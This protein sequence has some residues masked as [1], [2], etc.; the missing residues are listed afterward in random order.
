MLEFGAQYAER[1]VKNSIALGTA[2]KK[3]G[4]PVKMNRKNEITQSHQV[5]LKMNSN[6]G[7]EAKRIL[8]ECGINIDAF[9]RIGTAEVTR[10]GYKEKEMQT[11]AELLHRVM[12]DK[13]DKSTIK[14]E[15]EELTSV[16]SEIEYCFTDIDD[17]LKL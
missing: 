2:L 17:A 1:V 8:E 3:L 10:R 14:P 9:I 15:I 13:E 7:L 11:I 16:H 4:L 6:Q 12:V 5:I